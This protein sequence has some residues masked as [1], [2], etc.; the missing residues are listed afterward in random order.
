MEK[1]L[2]E[3]KLSVCQSTKLHV[4]NQTSV[5]IKE[6]QVTIIP[7]SQ[8]LE[9]RLGVRLGVQ[10]GV[11]FRAGVKNGIVVGVRGIGD[12]ALVRG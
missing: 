6:R 5:G 11:G 1:L 4:I 12:R 8:S 3:S 2:E 7:P 9:N 10:L